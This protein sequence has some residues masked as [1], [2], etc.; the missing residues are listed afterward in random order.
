MWRSAQN[1]VTPPVESGTAAA[2]RLH[3]ALGM[4]SAGIALGS[5]AIGAVIFLLLPR[6]SRG[7]LSGFN[8]QPTLISGFTDDVELGEIGEIKKS[9]EVVMRISVDGGIVAAQGV[10]WRG[11]ALTE[12]DGKR[13]YNVPREPT[14]MTPTG[15]GWFHVPPDQE[16]PKTPGRTIHYTV[17]LEPIASTALFFANNV[18]GVRGRF[19]GEVN[20]TPYSQRRT[21]LL[22]DPTGSIFNPY[23]NYSRME[24]EARS[25]LPV[26]P[27][28]EL[29]Q[30]RTTRSPLPKRIFNCQR[31]T[32]AFRSLPR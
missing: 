30:G 17:L 21:Y 8:L 10:H 18:E 1:A 13:W 27:P 5:L 19:D 24:Y 15:E 7:Y 14:T 6:F 23:H 28:A 3:N 12:F 25:V 9:S 32:C 26:I 31:S 2:R 22:K 11:I 20:T 29:R 16:N 4:T